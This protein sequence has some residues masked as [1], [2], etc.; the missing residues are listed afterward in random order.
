MAFIEVRKNEN[1]ESALRRFKKKLDTEGTLKTYKDNQYFRKPSVIKREKIKEAQRKRKIEELKVEKAK[2]QHKKK[3]N[4][5]KPYK[6][7]S[8]NGT[9]E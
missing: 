3:K 7:S 1:L 5:K 2:F 8:Q 6:R 4:F 9:D